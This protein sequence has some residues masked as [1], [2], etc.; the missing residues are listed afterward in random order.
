MRVTI[1]FCQYHNGTP[2]KNG[3]D[4]NVSICS[5]SDQAGERTSARHTGL[6]PDS[7]RNLLR[8]LREE[9]AMR[10]LLNNEMNHRIKNI[11]A[12]VQA[13]LNQ[14]LHDQKDIR[15]KTIA[16]ITSLAATNDVLVKADWSG[17]SLRGIL[18]MSSRPMIFRDF[19]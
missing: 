9:E 5:C 11:L 15:D 13:I 1:L 17:A 4:A 18:R 12:N 7:Y 8:R 19:T 2:V 16:R 14:T 3:H 10:R 6:L